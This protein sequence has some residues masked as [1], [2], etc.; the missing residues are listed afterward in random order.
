MSSTLTSKIV[1]GG[2]NDLVDLGAANVVAMA[3]DTT[4]IGGA[5]A[6]LYTASAGG[7]VNQGM[8][9]QF[10]AGDSTLSAM[11]TIAIGGGASTQFQF[12][13]EP[14]SVQLASFSTASTDSTAIA[15]ATNG[16]VEFVL[17]APVSLTARVEFLDQQITTTGQVAIFNNENDNVSYLFIQ[18]GSVDTVV[19]IGTAGSI[20]GASMGI[21]SDNKSFSATIA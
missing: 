11:D 17:D 2:D 5:G 1:L 9:F 14:G 15:S 10:S 6:D 4:I 13:Y 8:R 7:N 12:N 19:Q 18:G 21:A 16:V 20:S 3:A